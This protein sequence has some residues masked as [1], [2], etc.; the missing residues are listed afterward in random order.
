MFRPYQRGIYCDDKSISY[1]YRKDTI[2]HGT[3]AAVTIIC[4]IVIVSPGHWH[5]VHWLKYGTKV[6]C[7][8]RG[9]KSIS[10]HLTV[11]VIL[12]MQTLHL[13]LVLLSPLHYSS[14]HYRRG[15]PRPHQTAP[16][17]LPVQPVPVGPLQDCGHLPVWR[18]CEP[19][20]DRLGKIHHRSPPSK[21]LICVRPS[22]L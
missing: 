16:L 9:R 1:P 15:L 3:M 13:T 7:N 4:S 8:F 5:Q 11:L 22:Q 18:S 17:Q 12:Q 10:L 20:T 2:S 19:V 6:M 21:L 14:D